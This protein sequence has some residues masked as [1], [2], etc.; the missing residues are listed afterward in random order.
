MPVPIDHSLE[1]DMR[2]FNSKF[3]PTGNWVKV[4]IRSA[5]FEDIDAR[6]IDLRYG[7]HEVV[8]KVINNAPNARSEDDEIFVCYYTLGNI[9]KRNRAEK[10]LEEI[11]KFYR[12]S[13][14]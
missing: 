14:E 7:R 13:S 9:E 4:E 12:R 2:Y 8:V 11:Y 5:E 6:T 3:P 10:L 1:G